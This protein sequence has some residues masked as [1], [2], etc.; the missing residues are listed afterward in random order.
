M[1]SKIGHR[2]RHLAIDGHRTA[3][4]STLASQPR[5]S[6]NAGP[7]HTAG[8][9]SSNG[10]GDGSVDGTGGATAPDLEYGHIPTNAAVNSCFNTSLSSAQ[11]G[12]DGYVGG[13]LD[14]ASTS[15]QK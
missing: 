10:A 4:P 13:G 15:S 12:K 11:A 14:V 3:L 7:A 8:G 9:G 2:D 5:Y 1:Q 6:Q